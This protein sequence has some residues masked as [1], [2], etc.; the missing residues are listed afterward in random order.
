MGFSGKDAPGQIGLSKIDELVAAAG[1]D[2][3]F[4]NSVKPLA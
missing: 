4:A 2:G 3:A 1:Q